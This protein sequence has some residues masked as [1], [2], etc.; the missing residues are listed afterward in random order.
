MTSDPLD[1]FMHAT[2]PPPDVPDER[3][4]AVIDATLRRIDMQSARQAAGGRH[5]LWAALERIVTFC[6]PPVWRYA[7]SLSTATALGLIVGASLPAVSDN[8]M[9]N[10]GGNALVVSFSS[11]LTGF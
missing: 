2:F 11:T 5:G 1:N 6:S 3:L 9:V 7:V 4:N 10:L 8:T